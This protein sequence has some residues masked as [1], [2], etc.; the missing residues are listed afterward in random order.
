MVHEVEKQIAAEVRAIEK[1]RLRAWESGKASSAIRAH[2]V[3]CMGGA[4][5]LIDDCSAKATCA[6]WPWRSGLR[7]VAIAEIEKIIGHKIVSEYKLKKMQESD[8]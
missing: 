7:K 8:Q 3:E 4:V 2:C 5:H 1:Y 6:L